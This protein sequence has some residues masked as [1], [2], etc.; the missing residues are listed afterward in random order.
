MKKI[1]STTLSLATILCILLTG[2]EPPLSSLRNVEAA[3]PGAKI[4]MIDRYGNMSASTQWYVETQDARFIVW[5]SDDGV[6]IHEQVLYTLTG[7]TL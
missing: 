7:K 5:C 6:V 3:Y 1:K 4:T 2:C